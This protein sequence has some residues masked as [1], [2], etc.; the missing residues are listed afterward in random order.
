MQYRF[1]TLDK[2]F[3]KDFGGAL[4]RGNA[5][6][7]RPISLK[8]PLHL[9]MRS[10]MARGQLSFLNQKR[11]KRIEDLLRRTAAS[12][13]VKL[14]R[15]ANSGNHLHLIVLPS[16]REAFNSFVRAISGLI[17]RLTL[18]A[19]KGSAK[20]LKFWDARP[21]TRI[22]EWGRDFTRACAYVLQNRL[23]ALGFIPY[24]PRRRKIRQIEV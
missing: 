1:K 9:V 21:F 23:E 8:R 16:S 22:I 12:N 10:S 14:Y 17:A 24:R 2:E 11:R 7:K 19:E 3:K 5:R 13:D 20:G 15:Y 6:E 4:L 18:G